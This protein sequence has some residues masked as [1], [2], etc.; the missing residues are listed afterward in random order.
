M[1]FARMNMI[2]IFF[3]NFYSMNADRIEFGGSGVSCEVKKFT[4]QITL[5]LG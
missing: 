1:N 4:M 3:W 2:N 5:V